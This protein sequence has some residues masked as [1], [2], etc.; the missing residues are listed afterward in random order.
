MLSTGNE[1]VNLCQESP[2]ELAEPTKIVTVPMPARSMNTYIFMINHEETGIEEVEQSCND[3]DVA[4][5]TLYDL[6][7]NRYA[8]SDQLNPGIYIH[9]GKKVLIK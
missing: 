9:N 8:N 7:G 6:L 1:A 5:R 2:I 3:Y 4:P